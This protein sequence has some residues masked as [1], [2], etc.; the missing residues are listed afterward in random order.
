MSG[1]ELKNGKLD[2]HG[3]HKP[4]GA[5]ENIG[6]HQQLMHDDPP[7]PLLRAFSLLDKVL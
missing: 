2:L 6:E 1:E 5:S 7:P 4:Q 3:T